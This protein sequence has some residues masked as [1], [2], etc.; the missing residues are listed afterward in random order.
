VVPRLVTKSDFGVL[1]VI[2]E[3]VALNETD[4]DDDE[5]RHRGGSQED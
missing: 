2:A 4:D 1:Q 3:Y 5:G